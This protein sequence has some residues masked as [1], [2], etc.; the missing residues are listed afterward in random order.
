MFS[1][2]NYKASI[3][4]ILYNFDV[5]PYN[6]SIVESESRIYVMFIGYT[7]S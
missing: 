6:L 5:K 1:K 2:F 7:M 4:L 3:K